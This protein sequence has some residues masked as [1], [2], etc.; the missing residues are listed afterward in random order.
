MQCVFW[1]ILLLLF[2]NASHHQGP[3]PGEKVARWLYPRA[4]SCEI[5]GV[6]GTY[7]EKATDERLGLS[8]LGLRL[9]RRNGQEK[10]QGQ[11]NLSGHLSPGIIMGGGE[12]GA[13]VKK[14]LSAACGPVCP[15]P[16]SSSQDLSLLFASFLSCHV[17]EVTP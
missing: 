8:Y 4:R 11:T 13:V 12:R 17:L 3:E 1:K 16:L 2:G 7:S 15:R 6:T 14:L 5:I 9:C 10:N